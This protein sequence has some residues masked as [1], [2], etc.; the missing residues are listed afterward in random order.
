[1][2]AANAVCILHR[3]FLVPSHQQCKKTNKRRIN[4]QW[5]CTIPFVYAARMRPDT[6]FF[7][8][9]CEH[10]NEILLA[11]SCVPM[12]AGITFARCICS[13]HRGN[14]SVCT[15]QP[16]YYILTFVSRLHYHHAR[17]IIVNCIY[18]L[19]WILF[20]YSDA[21]Y[22]LIWAFLKLHRVPHRINILLNHRSESSA[23]PK[24]K[25]L[26]RLHRFSLHRHIASVPFI[27]HHCQLLN[28][29]HSHPLTITVDDL[30]NS[31]TKPSHQHQ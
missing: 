13:V 27:P 8:N 15:T 20:S 11:V 24:M 3:I 17:I 19:R 28:A 12:R 16:G 26:F 14:C 5:N 10:E 29:P 23:T 2:H 9:D 4:I 31:V 7:S 22:D 25:D 30:I 6:L 21:K 18:T 1:M